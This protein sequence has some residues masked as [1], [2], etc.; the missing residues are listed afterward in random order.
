M[1]VVS[2][3]IHID[4]RNLSVPMKYKN[5]I[6]RKS[7]QQCSPYVRRTERDR[8]IADII[9]KYLDV[10]RFI[11][12]KINKMSALERELQRVCYMTL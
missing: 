8:F 2:C 1:S 5:S 6:K 4:L 3:S 12:T 10:H 7:G 9:R 11:K